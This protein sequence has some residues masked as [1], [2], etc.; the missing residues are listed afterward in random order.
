M[1]SEICHRGHRGRGWTR[2]FS[3]FPALPSDK[4][5]ASCSN[6]WSHRGAG[7]MQTVAAERFAIEIRRSAKTKCNQPRAPEGCV[8]RT[9]AP[10]DKKPPR[11]VFNGARSLVPARLRSIDALTPSNTQGNQKGG[12]DY[13]WTLSGGGPDCLPRRPGRRPD[14]LGSHRARSSPVRGP[15]RRGASIRR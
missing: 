11:A 1:Q 6:E 5:R 10:P 15:A 2:S 3:P 12:V 14:R 7:K 13:R 9:R 4:T 8:R